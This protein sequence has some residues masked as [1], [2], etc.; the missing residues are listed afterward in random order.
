MR[1]CIHAT[2]AFG[3]ATTAL[4]ACTSVSC[5]D[6]RTDGLGAALACTAGG[7][8]QAQTDA[9]NRQAS[10]RQ[11]IAEQLAA[12]NTALQAQM[13]DLDAQERAVTD[14]LI[15]LNSR[16]AAL[17]TDLTQRL[18][19]Q[20]ITPEEHDLAFNELDAINQQ[21]AGIG[22]GDADAPVQIQQLQDESGVLQ[23]L[24]E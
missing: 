15:D 24:F 17:E 11:A 18:E 21:R 22:P 10:Q 4:T 3:I 5:G 12:E 19:R 16:I 20:E 14:Q 13:S 23:D 1:A 9:L 7:G 2:V 8:Y 6:P